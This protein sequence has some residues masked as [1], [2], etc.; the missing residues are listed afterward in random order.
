MKAKRNVQSS[1]FKVQSSQE[2][3]KVQGSGFRV[4]KKTRVSTLNV[5][6]RTLNSPEGATLNVEHRTLNSRLLR[7]AKG[8]SS[9]LLLFSLLF[10]FPAAVVAD[11][12]WIGADWE[13]LDGNWAGSAGQVLTSNGPAAPPTWESQVTPAQGGIGVDSS[14]LSGYPSLSA[15]TWSFLNAAQLKAALGYFTSADFP[16]S[17]SV[18]GWSNGQPVNNSA[19][20][21]ITGGTISGTTVSGLTLTS[22]ADGF[23]LAGGTTPR[24]FTFLGGAL[25]LTAPSGGA[26]LDLATGAGT[27]KVQ[28]SDSNGNSSWQAPPSGTVPDSGTTAGRPLQSTGS[29][30]WGVGGY[31]LL[32]VQPSDD[33]NGGIVLQSLSGNT[34][35]IYRKATSSGALT[36]RNNATETLYI[37]NGQVG[38]G[39]IPS[40]SAG[41]LFIQQGSN[42]GGGGL[43]FYSTDSFTSQIYREGTS[44]GGLAFRNNATVTAWIGGG[45]FFVGTEAM[46]YDVQPLMDRKTLTSRYNYVGQQIYQETFSSMG[47]WTAATTTLAADATNYK[48]G[49]QALEA[50]PDGTATNNHFY[51]T[52][53]ATNLSG[54]QGMLRFY[55]WPGTTGQTTDFLR[56][57]GIKVILTDGGAK[58]ATYILWDS[59]HTPGV[60]WYE[61]PIVF[62]DPDSQDSGFT[63]TTVSKIDYYLTVNA[64][65][66]IPSVTFDELLAFKSRN[67]TGYVLAYTD[68]TYSQQYA[69]AAYLRSLPLTASGAHGKASVTF[70]TCPL[71]V[72]VASH[73]TLAQF[74]DL[75]ASG[76]SLGLYTAQP[77]STN[78]ISLTASQK[79][80][81]IAYAQNY[82]AANNLPRAR[83]MSLVG[84]YGWTSYDHYTFLGQYADIVVGHQNFG[85]STHI[86][87]LWDQRYAPFASW[88]YS[89]AGLQT[90]TATVNTSTNV[91]TL[92]S[93]VTW[94]IGYPKP[95]KFSGDVMP[96]GITAGAIYWAEMLTNQTCNIYPTAH[97]AVAGTNMMTFASAGTNVSVTSTPDPAWG[98]R[99]YALIK[100]RGLWSWGGHVNS[101]NSLANGMFDADAFAS[102]VNSG[103]AQFVTP[104]ELIAG[105]A[106]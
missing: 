72:G 99:V 32:Q 46:G 38:V 69:F 96:T 37:L 49:T 20:V 41:Q 90:L 40:A 66:D 48:V 85:G 102:M 28:T 29:H 22:N 53:S 50:T 3:F 12:D 58:T 45:Y 87:S 1:R 10:L 81:A 78:W 16:V 7:S 92:G 84:D 56:I 59:T 76:H 51:K 42:D 44:T 14:A 54:C 57:T 61:A 26:T 30:T 27:G 62:D 21:A 71:E 17:A 95:V 24:T 105:T 6:H 11:P 73:L 55:I 79:L 91:V 83:V 104:D 25:T 97:D 2:L 94:T 88:V 101:T 77:S 19:N 106:G 74:Q 65:G 100:S 33:S 63:L 13:V 68:G 8:A 67:S 75:I 60:S 9:M 15:G 86:T 52:I 23:S 5:E 18:G 31:S 64:I 47:G 4:G 98:Q 82:F 70:N 34:A 80:A 93:T 103:D 36:F 35:Q 43:T 89:A 39:I